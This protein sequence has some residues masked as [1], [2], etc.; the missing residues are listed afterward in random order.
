MAM[1][2]LQVSGQREF[3]AKIG[4]IDAYEGPKIA[5]RQSLVEF[6]RTSW[7]KPGFQTKTYIE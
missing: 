1:I 2:R 7:P 6:P 4:E 3:A 5:I